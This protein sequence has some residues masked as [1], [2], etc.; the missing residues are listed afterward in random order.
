MQSGGHLGSASMCQ[1]D[2]I[3]HIMLPR[4]VHNKDFAQQ[5]LQWRHNERNG[6][7]NHLTII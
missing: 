1:H 4:R 2:A 5:S 7:L 3:Q 6:F